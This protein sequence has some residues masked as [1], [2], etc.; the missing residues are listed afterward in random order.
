MSQSASTMEL[1][2]ADWSPTTTNLGS[3]SVV[4][5]CSSSSLLMAWIR[6]RESAPRYSIASCRSDA[7][8]SPAP[9]MVVSES[10]VAWVG[11]CS[12]DPVVE[13]I[14]CARLESGMV[15]DDLSAIVSCFM[16]RFA[17]V[18][19]CWFEDVRRRLYSSGQCGKRRSGS[20]DTGGKARPVASRGVSEAK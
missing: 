16:R 5:M 20:N 10:S 11:M 12:G 4:L 3:C 19:W 14:V 17:I 8:P 9:L 1:L 6:R 18:G 13:L 2:P 15:G 7:A